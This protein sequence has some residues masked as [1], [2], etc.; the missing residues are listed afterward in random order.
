MSVPPHGFRDDASRLPCPC[1]LNFLPDDPASNLSY[2][3]SKSWY[4]LN[5]RNKNFMLITSLQTSSSKLLIYLYM[6]VCIS[7]YL[8]V[9]DAYIFPCMCMYVDA[10]GFLG[11]ILQVLSTCFYFHVSHQ[12]EDCLSSLHWLAH[13][14]H[15][16]ALAC[17]LP[18]VR[19]TNVYHETWFSYCGFCILINALMPYSLNFTDS[20][21]FLT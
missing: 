21:I 19:I 13:E 12:S 14:L 15:G 3:K 10:R 9:A 2:G 4:L 8:Y 17:F 18:S 11:V 5:L 20:V 16:S 1:W 6:C 7:I